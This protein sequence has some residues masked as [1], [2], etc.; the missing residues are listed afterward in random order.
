MKNRSTTGI[1]INAFAR[2]LAAGVMLGLLSPAAQAQMTTPIAGNL[3]VKLQG[4]YT[5]S[6]H[7]Y[8]VGGKV[9]T[10][11]EPA[12]KKAFTSSVEVTSQGLLGINPSQVVNVGGI[13]GCITFE[14][15]AKKPTETKA[16]G[17]VTGSL[18]TD[19]GIYEISTGTF[20]ATLNPAGLQ[21]IL[22]MWGTVFT[23]SKAIKDEAAKKITLVHAALNVLLRK[24]APL[25][26]T[27][28]P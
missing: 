23:K 15:G 14:A 17:T 19:N 2:L 5:P 18:S 3:S 21:V 26:P 25:P 4:I 16:S 20:T 8:I 12:I 13:S 27:P 6:T 22:Q 11:L 10:G 1:L 24:T 28:I 9:Q 7:L